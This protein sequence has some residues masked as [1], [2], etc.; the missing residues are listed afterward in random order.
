MIKA[1]VTGIPSMYEGEDLE[2]RYSVYDDEENLFRE[3]LLLDY[4]KP[5]VVGQFSV[6]TLLK[7]LAEFKTQP[8]EIVINDASLDEFI[9]GTS[10]TRNVDILKMAR[11]TRKHMDRYEHLTITN[12]SNDKTKLLKWKEEVEF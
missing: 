5:A 1:Y 10:G 6:V 12:V 8:V 3:K 9:K 7:R 11:E 2:I 4:R